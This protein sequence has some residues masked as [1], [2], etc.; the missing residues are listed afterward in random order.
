MR[1]DRGAALSAKPSRLGRADPQRQLLRDQ[2]QAAPLFAGL[3]AQIFVGHGQGGL[4]P[5]GGAHGQIQIA[6]R[7][8]RR[9]DR[10]LHL[11]LAAAQG[12]RQDRN[13][14]S[15]PAK[16]KLTIARVPFALDRAQFRRRGHGQAAGRARACRA[17]RRGRGPLRRGAR[18]SAL[19]PAKAIPTGRCSSAARARWST[20]P[21]SLRE[22]VAMRSPAPK[23]RPCRASA[24]RGRRP[25]TIRKCCRGG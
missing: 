17:R 10:R 5:A 6:A 24:S 8:A 20:T 16:D 21:S 18:R 12:R 19:P 14:R 7:A 22:Q 11:D 9:R 3:R 1:G 4:R 2:R 25:D 23:P 15:S 13:A